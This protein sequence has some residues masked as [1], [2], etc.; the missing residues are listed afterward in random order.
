MR[1]HTFKFEHRDG[2]G[3]RWCAVCELPENNARAKAMHAAAVIPSQRRADV[4]DWRARA[5]DGRRT[6]E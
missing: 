3:R 2:L 1:A 4:A 6:E 5:Y